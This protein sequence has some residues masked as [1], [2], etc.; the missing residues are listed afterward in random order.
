MVRGVR[1]VCAEN[2]GLHG[3]VAR[4]HEMAGLVMVTGQPVRDSDH[5]RIP[6]GAQPEV[7]RGG[8][9]QHAVAGYRRTDELR[10]SER[11]ALLTFDFDIEGDDA[12]ATRRGRRDN[13]TPTPV[14]HPA[15][16][17]RLLASPPWRSAR[18]NDCSI[19]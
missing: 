4:L 6:A 8:V 10:I 18:S 16:I 19:W 12:G 14:D 9:Q 5:Q 1:F 3:R 2:H 7:L 15:T 11:R 13:D 17:P